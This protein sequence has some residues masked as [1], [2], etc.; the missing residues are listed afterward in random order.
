M[1]NL[2]TTDELAKYLHVPKDTIYHF[3]HQKEK[4]EFPHYKLGQLLRFDPQKVLN[5]MID[6]TKGRR[7][8]R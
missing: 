1:D 4:T 7:I 8:T 5:W 6:N 3:V 2:M